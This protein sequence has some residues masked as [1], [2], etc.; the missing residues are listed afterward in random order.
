MEKKIEIEDKYLLV[1]YYLCK[2][3]ELKV[4]ENKEPV[5]KVEYFDRAYD[6]FKSG[7]GLNRE[8]TLVMLKQLLK[9]KTLNPITN[10]Q[11]LQMTQI[12]MNIQG[13]GFNE[14]RKSVKIKNDK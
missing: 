12:I 4:I 14:F 13:M 2:L 7:L 8:E 5:L 1:S 10:K 9:D 11:Y 3:Q 6:V